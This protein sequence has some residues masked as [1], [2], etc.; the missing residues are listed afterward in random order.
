MCS[1][2]VT[3]QLSDRLHVH[4]VVAHVCEVQCR[5]HAH[6]PPAGIDVLLRV[7]SLREEAGRLDDDVG[8]ELAPG[9]LR[10]VALRESAEGVRADGD[11]LVGV[12]NLL[13]EAAQDAVVLQQVDQRRVVGEVV[14]PDDLDVG[15][16]C[17]G[18]AEEVPA[19]TS[20]AVDAYADSHKEPLSVATLE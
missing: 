20:E 12:G 14:D 7:S 2:I 4:V 17:Q 15:A 1:A 3:L 6:D 16:R 13:A 5:E 11:G 18:R 10:R 9:Q 19:D 8:A